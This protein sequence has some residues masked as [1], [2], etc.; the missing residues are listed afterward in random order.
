MINKISKRLAHLIVSD[1]VY[2]FIK[3]YMH[4]RSMNFSFSVF[5]FGVSKVTFDYKMVHV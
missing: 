5:Y 2:N 4:C 3:I 1:D